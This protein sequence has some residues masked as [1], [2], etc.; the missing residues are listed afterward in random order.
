MYIISVPFV[1]FSVLSEYTSW[2]HM[3]HTLWHCFLNLLSIKKKKNEK[4]ENIYMNVCIYV[5]Y[6]VDFLNGFLLLGGYN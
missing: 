4:G 2:V 3:L 6:H 1:L 5:G